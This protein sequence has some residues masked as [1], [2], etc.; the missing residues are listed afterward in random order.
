MFRISPLHDPYLICSA[1]SCSSGFAPPVSKLYFVGGTSC[2]APVFAGM[3]ALL[4]QSSGTGQGNVNAGLYSLASFNSGTFHDVE[5]G[6]N[7][8]PCAPGTPNCAGTFGYPAG[9][10]YDQVTGL[11]SVDGAQLVEQWGSDFQVTLNPNSLTLPFGSSANASLEVTRFSNF[12]GTV[13]FT[14]TVSSSLTNTTCSVPASIKSSSAGTLTIANSAAARFLKLPPVTPGSL[15]LLAALFAMLLIRAPRRGLLLGG[16][17]AMCM[18]SVSCGGGSASTVSVTSHAISG[19]VTV[20]ATSGVLQ[21][22]I[23]IPVY[24]S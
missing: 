2:A 17:A 6:D 18:V 13:N 21:R 10:G 1:G 22:S 16:V 5:L 14:C 7:R 20:T 11:G 8:V 4:N 19:T 23:V 24:I 15:C 3:L 9:P 12:S